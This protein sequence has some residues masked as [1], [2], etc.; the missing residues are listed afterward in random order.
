[1][2]SRQTLLLKPM[3]TA[4]GG[5]ARVQTENGRTLVQLHARGLDAGV[6]RVF[7]YLEGRAARELGSVPVNPSGEASLEAEAPDTLRGLMVIRAPATPLLIALCGKQDAG[8]LLDLKNAALALCER[9]GRGATAAKVSRAD[10]AG[11]TEPKDS[12]ARARETYGARA[13][14]D[15]RG[16]GGLRE[17]GGA[18]VAQDM[19]V[20]QALPGARTAAGSRG[21][22]VAGEAAVS[23]EM[24]VSRALPV[25]LSQAAPHSAPLPREIFLPALD[26]APYVTAGEPQEAPS[27]G[28]HPPVRRDAPAADRLRPLAWPRG[29]A[30]LRAYFATR[31]PVALLPWPGWRFVSAASGLWLGIQVWDGMAR[32][33]AYVYGGPTPPDAGGCRDVTGTD[34]RAYHILVQTPRP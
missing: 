18:E 19:A 13:L 21:A 33:V 16:A 9:L 10:D 7:A 1:M 14:L 17:A 28:T 32:R 29:F 11:H 25:P 26:P 27:T 2:L 34:G 31:K 4:A 30:T 6:A 20:A 8:G 23:Q 22:T 12:R 15:S 5:F 24:P 3:Q